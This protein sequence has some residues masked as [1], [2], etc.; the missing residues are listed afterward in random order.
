[1]NVTMVGPDDANGRSH[2]DPGTYGSDLM[3]PVPVDAGQRK[4]PSSL[5]FEMLGRAF[6]YQVCPEPSTLAIGVLGTL[7]MLG[8]SARRRKQAAAA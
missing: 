5:D 2:L 6:G 1:M 3:V 4:G 8:Y 7:G